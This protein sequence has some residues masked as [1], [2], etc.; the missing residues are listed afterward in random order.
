M[1]RSATGTPSRVCSL[2]RPY[3]SRPD[4]PRMGRHLC[5]YVQRL[6]CNQSQQCS[7]VLN[8]NWQGKQC[9]PCFPEGACTCQL[10]TASKAHPAAQ[11]SLHCTRM[12]SPRCLLWVHA[13]F[14]GT[15]D[16]NRCL[17]LLCMFPQ[18]IRHMGRRQDLCVLGHREGE[19]HTRMAP[20]SASPHADIAGK[21]CTPCL[22]RR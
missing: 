18:G 15:P 7:Q 6:Q 19:D 9:N 10:G 2:S 13:C 20:T 17:R 21:R 12:H 4:I 16:K 14:L 22:H 5:R 11:C 3:T 1:S 8:R